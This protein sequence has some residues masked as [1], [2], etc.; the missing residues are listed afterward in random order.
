MNAIISLAPVSVGAGLALE[1]VRSGEIMRD[2]PRA[3]PA[4]LSGPAATAD[5][6]V[7]EALTGTP[8]YLHKPEGAFFFWLWF[9]DLPISSAELYERLKRRGVLIVPGHYFYPG[10]EEVMGT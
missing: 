10:L 9:K 6:W 7:W 2:Q 5:E 8:F 1:M 4:L 3:D